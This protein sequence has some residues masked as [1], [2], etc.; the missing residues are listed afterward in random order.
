MSPN[1]YDLLDV[2][3][4]ASGDEIRAAWKA[5]IA[6]LDPTDRRFRAY[7]DAAGVL[8]DADK[9]S[10]YDAELAARRE[11]DADHE[12]VAE[13]ATDAEPVQPAEPAEAVE[14][15]EP[16]ESAAPAG[17]TA[18]AARTGGPG[19]W[20]IGLAAVAAVL[21]VVLAIWTLTQPDVKHETDQAAKLQA[22]GADVQ[23]FVGD[24]VV[25]ATLSYDYRTMDEDLAGMQQYMTPQEAAVEARNWQAITRE[26]KAQHAVVTATAP[27]TGLTRISPDGR[28][29][30]VA[31]F[32]NQQT[33][34][35]GVKT[36]TLQMGVTFMLD[37][38]PKTGA[39]QVDGFCPELVCTPDQGSAGSPGTAP[40]SAPT[41]T[42]GG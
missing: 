30:V 38:D 19:L 7:N 15:A 20:S 13:P 41:T 10:A 34:K 16:V 39:W 5:A 17:A 12:E 21:A 33:R 22:E 1:L 4:N 11:D 8:L 31:A 3:E 42:P 26:A 2:D 9:R 27:M 18:A 28:T 23:Q 24:K 14:P 25:P 35:Q 36:F 6:D 29:A 32:V 37:R 40:S